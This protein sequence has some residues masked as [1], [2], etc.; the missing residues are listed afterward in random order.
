MKSNLKQVMRLVAVAFVASLTLTACGKGCTKRQA[1]KAESLKLIPVDSNVLIGIN[2]KKTQASPLGPKLS[3]GIPPEAKALLQN[4]D[5]LVLGANVDSIMPTL[6]TGTPKEPKDVIGVV[7]GKVD[8]EAWLKEMKDRLAKN[9]ASPQEEDYEGVKI[10][11]D[12]TPKGIS[13]AF[14]GEQTLFG[15]KESVKKAIDLSKGKGDSIEKNKAVMDIVKGL[16]KGKMLWAVAL[17]PEGTIPAGAEGGAGNPMNALS[18]MKSLDLALDYNGNLLLDLGIF[19]ATKESAQQMMTMANSYK[20]LFG[21]T[22]ASKSPELGKILG[23]LSIDA[24][25]NKVVLTLKLDQATV[26]ELAKKA[27][28]GSP[29]MVP[30]SNPSEVVPPAASV[31]PETAPALP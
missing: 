27:K 12:P 29:G 3:E 2:W 6:S 22:L 19:T 5:S 20:T 7:D 18:S 10:Y 30:P 17:I 24:K 31:S 13:I 8:K 23:G 9:S 1:A 14:L 11:S 21:G 16:D 15:M 4:I 26:E 28:E 25:E